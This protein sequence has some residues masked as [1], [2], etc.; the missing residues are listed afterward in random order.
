MTDA[1]Q[2]QVSG[3]P[4]GSHTLTTKGVKFEIAQPQGA[5][6]RYPR[7]LRWLNYVKCDSSKLIS[8]PALLVWDGC[9]ALHAGPTGSNVW[10]LQDEIHNTNNYF[11]AAFGAGTGFSGGTAELAC[12]ALYFAG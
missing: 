6:R 1:L 10:Y 2:A 7:R 11:M 4:D 12:V 8:P 9:R 5:G 3:L